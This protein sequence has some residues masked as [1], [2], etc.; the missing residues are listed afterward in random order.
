MRLSGATRVSR[1]SRGE[2]H[3][4]V[5]PSR[6]HSPLRHQQHAPA[7]GK[8]HFGRR[9]GMRVHETGRSAEEAEARCGD[10]GLAHEGK[11]SRVALGNVVTAS[12]RGGRVIAS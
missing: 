12:V 3:Q 5:Y 1:A 8:L 2:V 4:R 10:G 7:V 6:R 11:P 9:S